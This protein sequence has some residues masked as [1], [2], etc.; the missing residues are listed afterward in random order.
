MGKVLGIFY[1]P[2]PRQWPKVSL[3][4]QTPGACVEYFSQKLTLCVI[5]TALGPG[6]MAIQ[7]TPKTETTDNSTFESGS[8]RQKKVILGFGPP[9]IESALADIMV[10]G[11]CKYE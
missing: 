6:Y 3:R 7:N 8:K 9:W 11:R 2:R 10:P 1:P 4:A 5:N